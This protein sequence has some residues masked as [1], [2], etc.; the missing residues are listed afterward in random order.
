MSVLIQMVFNDGKKIRKT[1][2][3]HIYLVMDAT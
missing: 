1:F 3:I 2:A